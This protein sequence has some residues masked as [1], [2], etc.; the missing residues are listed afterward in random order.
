MSRK[1][2]SLIPRA[3]KGITSYPTNSRRKALLGP[4]HGEHFRIEYSTNCDM[5]N[6]NTIIVKVP[7][8]A[9]RM[10][11][12]IFRQKYQLIT[13]TP[14]TAVSYGQLGR[15]RVFQTEVEIVHHL[16]DELRSVGII[17]HIEE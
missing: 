4:L 17:F 1:L 10:L 6:Y 13:Y 14:T 2:Y 12:K 15:A 3:R 9:N 11:K 5:V 8:G 7:R 16:Y